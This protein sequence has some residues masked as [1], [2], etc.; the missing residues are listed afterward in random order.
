MD[1]VPSSVTERTTTSSA[2]R[3]AETRIL[4]PGC[5]TY[6][7]VL[8]AHSLTEPGRA[9]LGCSNCGTVFEWRSV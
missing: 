3:V 8:V 2:P 5:W 6:A 4:C 7:M 1:S 9:I